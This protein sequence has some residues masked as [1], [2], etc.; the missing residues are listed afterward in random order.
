MEDLIQIS[1]DIAF[2]AGIAQLA[3]YVSGENGLIDE[4]EISDAAWY[5]GVDEWVAEQIATLAFDM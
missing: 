1:E 3:K 2:D 4:A 5:W